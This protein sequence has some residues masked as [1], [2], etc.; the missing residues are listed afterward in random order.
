MQVWTR[1]L[2]VQRK[3]WMYIN[4]IPFNN[5]LLADFELALFWRLHS[6]FNIWRLLRVFFG[7][8]CV[9]NVFLTT[10]ILYYE[11]WVCMSVRCVCVW[12]VCVRGIWCVCVRVVCVYVHGVCEHGVCVCVVCVFAWYGCVCVCVHGVCVHGV[13]VHGVCVP[14][15]CVRGVCVR[16][17][18]VRGVCVWYVCVCGRYLE[19]IYSFVFNN[20][21]IHFYYKNVILT[22]IILSSLNILYQ[23]LQPYPTASRIAWLVKAKY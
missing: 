5:C 6:G 3:M 10:L 11:T 22:C 2:Y 13:C 15:V 19:F 23:Y 18:C 14:G 9:K 8:V 12:C 20:F 4:L 21:F 7:E 16:G 17:V 1:I